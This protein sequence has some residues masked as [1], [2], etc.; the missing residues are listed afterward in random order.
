M[1]IA[2]VPGSFD[3]MTLGH[4]NL[5]E[6]VA[7]MF[8]EVFVAVMI[9]PQKKYRFTLEQKCELARIS[10][11]HI[12]NVH[13]IADQGMLIDLVDKLNAN[14]IVKGIRTLKD[15]RYEKTMAEWNLAHNPKAETLYLPSNS[16]F[17]R[18]SS[19]R[20]RQYIDEKKS[21]FRL[22]TPMAIEKLVEWGYTCPEKKRTSKH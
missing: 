9:N 15:Y 12:S 21:L 19:T 17:S 16:V 7:G 8:D 11:C 20:V 3:P 14:A 4:V 1:S 10:C 6:R 18:V 13:V 2:I 22:M 5:V